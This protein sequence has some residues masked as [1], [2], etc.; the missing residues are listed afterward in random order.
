MWKGVGFLPSIDGCMRYYLH[1]IP[2]RLFA[3]GNIIHYYDNTNISVW[4]EVVVM[5]Y[6][7]Y[8]YNPI[9]AN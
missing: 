3:G 8:Y 6:V 4:M 9:I 1:Y 2:P 5:T 7:R